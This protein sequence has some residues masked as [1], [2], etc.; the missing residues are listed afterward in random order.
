MPRQCTS[1][2]YVAAGT[3]EGAAATRYAARRASRHPART[4]D[5]ARA[6]RHSRKRGHAGACRPGKSSSGP[7]GTARRL[8]RTGRAVQGGTAQQF[9][10]LDVGLTRGRDTSAIYT[11]GLSISV[12][13][14]L[15][16]GNRG[17]IAIE[18]ATRE[19]LYEDYVQ[20]LDDAYAAVQGITSNLQLLQRQ[21]RTARSSELALK[22]SL[23]NARQASRLR[24]LA[25]PALAGIESQYLTQRIATENLASALLQQHV[26]LCTLIGVSAIDHQPLQRANP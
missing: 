14:P 10:K 13:L 5:A 9:P 11:S 7:A 22:T 24:N 26:A 2:Q 21:L 3:S 18:K 12:T 6:I 19:S 4:G 25:L 17:N 23:D 8:R 1:F 16:N 20:R 15:F